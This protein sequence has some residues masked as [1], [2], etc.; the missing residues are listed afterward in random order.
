[1][2]FAELGKV[3]YKLELTADTLE[4][5]F[6]KDSSTIANINYWLDKV[7]PNIRDEA[8]NVIRWL[9]P[10]SYEIRMDWRGYF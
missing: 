4:I 8:G 10:W 2:A 7:F 5:D 1:L 9:T 6:A 3:G